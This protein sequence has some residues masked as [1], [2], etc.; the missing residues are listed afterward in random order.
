MEFAGCCEE[1]T[2]RYNA[3]HGIAEAVVTSAVAL[4]AEQMAALKKSWKNQR[5]TGF[6]DSEDRCFRTG[7]SACGV[8]RKT[9]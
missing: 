3:D 8:G 9:A 4:N 6:P 1:F 2:R 5:E 7:R